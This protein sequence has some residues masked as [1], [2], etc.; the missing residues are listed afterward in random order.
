ME[1]IASLDRDYRY[2]PGELWTMDG[3]PYT[4]AGLWNE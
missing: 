4:Q 1:A 2:L 3:S